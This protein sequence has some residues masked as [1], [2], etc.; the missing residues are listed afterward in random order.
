M[1]QPTTLILLPQTA[2]QGTGVYGDKQ[3][4]AGYYVANKSLQTVTWS[5]TTFKGTMYVEASLVEN[6]TSNNDWFVV[7]TL[8]TGNSTLTQNGFENIN[9]NFVWLRV[10]ID[11]FDLHG[12]VQYIKV[13]Y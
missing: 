6:P 2:G 13:T 9:G 8:A 4:A 10:R 3:P 5:L 12:V 1:S 7:Y 11:P